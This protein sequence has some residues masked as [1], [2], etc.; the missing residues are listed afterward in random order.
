MRLRVEYAD[1]N[2]A[3][4][5]L[6][7]VEGLVEATPQCRDSSHKWHLLRLDSSLEYEGRQY[8]HLLLASRWSGKDIGGPTPPSVFILLVPEGETVANGFSHKQY[9]HVAWGMAHVSSS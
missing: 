9:H 8:S 6:L 3:F 7:P 5:S 4:A 1:H 2:E